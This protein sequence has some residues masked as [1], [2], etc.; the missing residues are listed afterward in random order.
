MTIP[1][2]HLV[3]VDDGDLDGDSMGDEEDFAAERL[4][5]IVLAALCQRWKM[6]D[7]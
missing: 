1:L 2:R 4:E 5:Y 6:G 3:R 7:G